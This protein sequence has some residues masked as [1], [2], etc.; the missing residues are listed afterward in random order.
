MKQALLKFLSLSYLLLFFGSIVI[1]AQNKEERNVPEFKGI[2][3][4]VA[5]NVYV[6]QEVPQ[7]VVLEGPEDVLE[8]I[9]T[10]VENNKLKIIRRDWGF[11]WD[12]KI[13]IYISVAELNELSVS[14]SGN[15][16]LMTPLKTDY[17]DLNISGSGKIEIENLSANKIESHISGSG[18]LLLNGNNIVEDH[19]LYISGSGGM[20]AQNLPVNNY[21]I[22]IS[23][24]GSAKIKSLKNLNA[25][26]SGSGQIYYTG[27]ALIDANI[28]GS[29]KIKKMEN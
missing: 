28:S 12:K 3:L 13:N 24:S 22:K 15:I 18:D 10:E 11:G 25:N 5:A 4:G 27:D 7:K 23:G 1:Y 26:V 2:N 16:E 29:G 20:N 6:S 14:G 21:D 8:L 9:K 17:I 19:E